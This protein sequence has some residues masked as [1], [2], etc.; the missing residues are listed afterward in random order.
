MRRCLLALFLIFAPVGV[1]GCEFFNAI[2]GEQELPDIQTARERLAAAE[3]SYRAAVLSL[4]DITRAGIIEPESQLAE[5]V[6]TSVLSTR[7]GLDRWHENVDD[8]D[9][10]QA[11]MSGLAVLK[12]LVTRF[13][14]SPE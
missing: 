9:L 3:I 8:P 5:Y 12:S 6:A 14:D 2:T 10:E 11:A 13:G 7:A 1:T 4:T